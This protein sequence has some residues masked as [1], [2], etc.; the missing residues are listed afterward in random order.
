MS[1]VK[2]YR[3]LSKSDKEAIERNYA[4]SAGC[5]YDEWLS[6]DEKDRKKLVAAIDAVAKKAARDVRARERE[7]YYAKA[8]GMTVDEWRE[9]DAKSRKDKKDAIDARDKTA[10][11][12]LRQEELERA[13]IAKLRSE[14][15]N[16]AHKKVPREEPSRCRPGT[17][18]LSTITGLMSSPTD[19]KWKLFLYEG[20]YWNYLV[21]YISSKNIF[22]GRRDRVEEA[23]QNACAKIGTFLVSKRYKYPEE[24]K[25]YFRGFIKVVALRAALDL[26]K[27]IRRQERLQV[28]ESSAVAKSEFDKM[29][30]DKM[31]DDMLRAH[32]RRS[33][34][35]G[36]AVEGG[37][38]EAVAMSDY[39]LDVYDASAGFA[40]KVLPTP[41]NSGPKMHDIASLDAN[42]F[43]DDEAPS[44]YAPAS[45]FDFKTKVSKKDI[46]WVEKLQ[47]HLIYIALGYVLTNERIPAERREMLRL[48]Y[49]LDMSVADIYA[50]PRFASKKR[51]AFDVMM[52]RATDDLRKEV[53]SWWNIAA[54]SK[55]D[56]ADETMLKLWRDLCRSEGRAKVARSMKEK[57][58]KKAGW[59]K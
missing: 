30:D 31:Q 39:D 5:S 21:S 13:A 4:K 34:R 3:G 36:S 23:V 37:K 54:P 53:R 22:G 2:I 59:F 12:K 15:K 18:R 26:L 58:I 9:L 25:G 7:R 42:P 38:P 56:F 16:L 20:P 55:N 44:T 1:K 35:L 48:R 43:S 41:S 14:A 19:R 6:L 32:A 10:R 29:Q 49:G 8:C 47:I 45:F 46:S 24:G 51:N 50:L 17:T 28:D 11:A 52:N 57:A 40:R 27:D 33:R